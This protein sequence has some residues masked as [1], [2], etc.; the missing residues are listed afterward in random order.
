MDHGQHGKIADLADA[1]VPDFAIVEALVP[2]C[3]DETIKNPA[4]GVETHAVLF[5]IQPVL[6]TVSFKHVEKM[7]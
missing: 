1:D 7:L 3:K 6:A 4:R 5:D 2:D